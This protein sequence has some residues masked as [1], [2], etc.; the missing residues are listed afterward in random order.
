MDAVSPREAFYGR[1]V[2]FNRDLRIGF[3]EYVQVHSPLTE[4]E[5]RRTGLINCFG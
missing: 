5:K 3:G 1:K 4:A 2:D